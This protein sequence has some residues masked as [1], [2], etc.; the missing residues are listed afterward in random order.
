MTFK[1]IPD[2]AYLRKRLLYEPE[3]GTLF[4]RDCADMSNSWRARYAGTEAFT[5]V[6]LGYRTGRI[7]AAN[8][9]A[10]RIAWSIY[11]GEW[12]SNQIDHIN[13]IRTDNRIE[14]LRVVTPQENMRNRAM[15]RNNTSG[16]CGVSWCKSQ[17]K[18]RVKITVD[19]RMIHLGYFQSIDEAKTVRAEASARYEF[20]KRH[21][22]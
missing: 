1:K 3:T 7:D 15:N 20:T 22:T 9:K 14:N 17:K 18:W 12:P 4:W 11:Y 10:H 5:S 16:T 2:I 21:G 13:G 8:F 6:C 19:D